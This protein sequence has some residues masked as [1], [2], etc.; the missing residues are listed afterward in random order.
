MNVN[1]YY[2]HGTKLA[3][4]V[5]IIIHEKCTKNTAIIVTT[6]KTQRMD[7]LITWHSYIGIANA[8]AERKYN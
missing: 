6:Y 2:Y 1:H 3:R 8:I 7:L 5:G 4:E